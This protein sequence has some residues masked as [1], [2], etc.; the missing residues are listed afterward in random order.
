MQSKISLLD[1]KLFLSL[2]TI[3]I[4]YFLV[5]VAIFGQLS[6]FA[7]GGED[8]GEEQSS[9]PITSVGEVNT[10]LAKASTAEALIK[11]PTPKFGEEIFIR[12]FLTDLITNAPID[13]AKVTLKFQYLGP[14]QK[15]ALSFVPNIIPTVHAD[16]SDLVINANTTNTVGMYEAKVTFS[17]M[18]QYNLL[19]SFN[20]PTLDAQAFISGIMVLPKPDKAISVTGTNSTLLTI[21]IALS[22]LIMLVLLYLLFLPK[23]SSTQTKAQENIL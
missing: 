15:S 20:S 3:L 23:N 19:A 13:K 16:S 9:V 2:K 7:H 10:K 14:N 5:L 12:V 22:A 4:L 11:Y 1:K 6:V 17:N 8:H 21:V 18:G